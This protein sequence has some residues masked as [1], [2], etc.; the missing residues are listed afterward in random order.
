MEAN[1]KKR[2][3]TSDFVNGM[4]IEG[5]RQ[6]KKAKDLSKEYGIPIRTLYGKWKRY[7]QEGTLEKKPK[8]GRPKITTLRED[9]RMFREV[10]KD[11]FI[12]CKQIGIAIGR[13][14]LSEQ[15]EG[16]MG[17]EILHRIRQALII[18]QEPNKA[19]QMGMGS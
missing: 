19:A 9:I 8:S 18:E 7:Q 1:P 15:I 5:F 6:G 13:P 11:P 2:K 3:I 17:A 16:S 4:V 12:S 14:D 10:K